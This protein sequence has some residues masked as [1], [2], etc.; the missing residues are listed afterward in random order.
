MGAPT[1]AF[2]LS[3]RST[4]EDAVRQGAP[5]DRARIGLREWLGAVRFDPERSPSF[6]AFDTR[7]GKVRWLPKAAGPTAVRMAR[8]HGFRTVERPVAFIV[9]ELQGPLVE[10]ELERATALGQLL[11]ARC[12]DRR[13][14]PEVSDRRRPAPSSSPSSRLQG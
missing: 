10:G 7:I 1:H 14:A 8:K 3:R 9:A 6:A 13:A 11:G 5:A 4:R 2:S 12:R